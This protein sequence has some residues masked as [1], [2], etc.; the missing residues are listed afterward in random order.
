MSE[1]VEDRV[2]KKL[3][4]EFIKIESQILGDLSK[5]DEFLL[6]AQARVHS[7][8]VPVKSRNSSR[9]NHGTNEDRSQNDLHREVSVFLG[10]CLQGLST[11]E[12]SD[13]ASQSI[14]SY[15]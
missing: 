13:I 15:V 12:T 6:N 8:P 10:Q 11:E 1:E 5:L 9:E 7:G 2:T 4:Q 3:S 14:P